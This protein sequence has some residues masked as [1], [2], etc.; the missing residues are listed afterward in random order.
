MS[1]D[2]L[3]TVTSPE[4]FKSLLSADLDRVSCLNF[5]APWAEPCQAFNKSIEEEA[6]KFSQVLFLNI[7]AE[8]LSDISESFDIE[9][10]PSFLLLRGHTLLARH[11]GSDV[12]LLQS[13]LSQHSS[14]STSTSSSSSNTQPL[15]T[16]NAVPQAPTETPRQRTEEEIVARCKEL[17]NKHKVVLFM[18][19]NPT[20]PKCG[21]SRQTV[22]L[23]REQGVEFAWFDILSD[24]DVRQGLKKVNDWPTFPQII[25]NGELIGGLDILREMIENGEF[26]EI[27]NGETEDG[28]DEK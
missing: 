8:E 2:N 6:K 15:A 22:G 17:M 20:S 19:G 13:L 27:L 24:E 18:K 16:S 4:H 14:G 28:V 11:S 26:Q 12:S 25:V 21:F 10:V 9:A 5:W 7:E 23:L 3:V 1:S